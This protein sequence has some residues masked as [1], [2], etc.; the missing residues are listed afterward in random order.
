MNKHL[1]ISLLIIPLYCSAQDEEFKTIFNKEKKE[2][3]KISGF[4]SPIMNF[5]AIDNEF[6]LMMGGGCGVMLG[7]IFIGGYG[8]GKTNEIKY[9]NNTNSNDEYKLGYGHGGFWFGY[10]LYPKKAVHLS[11]STQ[12]GWGNISKINNLPEGE[13]EK[14][15]SHA[16]TVITPIVE[17]EYN[18]SR[19]CKIGT[20]GTWAYVSGIKLSDSNYSQNDFSKPS[21]FLSFKFGWFD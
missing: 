15:E 17:V 10:V 21:F 1:I 16:I 12:I 19:F 3:L 5:T 2:R 20:G 14:I 8:V 6:A 11:L 7:N 4:G 18:L 9:K 13:S